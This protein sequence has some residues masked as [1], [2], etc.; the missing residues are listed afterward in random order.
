MAD[1]FVDRRTDTLRVAGI[2]E[3]AG[4]SATLDAQLVHVD[5]DVIGGDTRLHEFTGEAQHFCRHL[6]CLAHAFDDIDRLHCRFRPTLHR[7]GICI[8]RPD[9]VRRDLS[10]GADYTG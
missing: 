3:G 4:V 2:V 9:D 7:A 6:S 8:G 10:H 1:H 5:I